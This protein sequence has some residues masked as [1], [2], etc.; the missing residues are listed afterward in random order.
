MYRNRHVLVAFSLLVGVALLTSPAAG[1][2]SGSPP[3]PGQ[4]VVLVTGST[5]G[6]GQEVARRIAA[7]GAHVIV[8]GRN[9]ERGMALV[10][11][12]E[13]EGSGSARFYA[14]DFA[15]FEQT[16]G[17]AE[18]ILRD[19]DRLDV[20]VNNAGFGSAPNE[21]LLSEDGHEFR[22]QVNYLA[23]FLLTK[24]L[25]PRLL[26]ST[27]SRIV[28]VSSLAANPIDF[29]DVMIEKNFSGGR[30]SGQSKLSQVMMTF[31]LAEELQ[32]TGVMVN[33]LH[34]AAYMDTGMVRRLGITPRATVDEGATAVMQ[35]VTS[36]EIEAGQFFVGLR[37][38]RANAQAYDSDARARLKRLSEEL[39]GVQ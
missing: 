21:R 6:L 24:M 31:D 8:H 34:P 26:S 16:R 18:A 3:S 25:M 22:F 20:L 5:G 19:Y 29:D 33:A 37:P 39:T 17:L 13:R 30:A 32:G 9:R 14:A 4:R 2:Q 10:Q 1:A 36:T 35:L 7:S 28:N 11:E 15:S 23:G 12:I 27:P 38:G